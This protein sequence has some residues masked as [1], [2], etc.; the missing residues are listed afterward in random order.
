MK[1]I[2]FD[3]LGK[4]LS[5][6]FLLLVTLIKF[7]L[8]TIT[9]RKL[10]NSLLQ[11]LKMTTFR[12]AL[13]LDVSDSYYVSPFSTKFLISSVGLRF[14]ALTSKLPGYGK[15]Y[16][17]NSI[18]LVRQSRR[19]PSDPIIIYI[20]GGGF[21]LET[22]PQQLESVLSIYSLLEPSKREKLSVLV[23]DYKLASAGHTFPVQMT[24]LHE[25]YSKLTGEDGN[26]NIILM[27]DSAG[28]NLS[29]CYLQ[30]LKSLSAPKE[31]YPTKL[32]LVSPWVNI[33]PN[34]DQNVPGRSFYDS[35]S[36]DMIRFKSFET[37]HKKHQIIGSCKE[38][39]VKVSPLTSGKRLKDDWVHIPT[40]NL[41]EYD[42]ILICGE[43]ESFRDDI[44]EFAEL[45]LEVPYYS[46][47]HYG[48]SDNKISKKM[49]YHRVNNPKHC[50]FSLFV[51][52]WGVHDASMFFENHLLSKV[53]AKKVKSLE[54]V[55]KTE[56]FGLYRIIE[57]LN[58]TL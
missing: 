57:F 35:D 31:R 39:D 20:H 34:S 45:A 7:Y 49:E 33:T 13:S 6:P 4:L 19:S 10:S 54:D 41:P 21:F 16:D 28:G 9:Y 48:D 51:E 18:W 1:M 37:E 12:L 58:K 42:V 50:N 46:T 27:G 11:C 25:T 23:L 32:V 40:L 53:K 2:L 14:R 24:Q 26:S 43:D 52:P 5:L 36:F 55:D 8:G 47:Y 15:R 3:G 56:F 17:R 38:T 44:L 30:Y 29:I 22:Q